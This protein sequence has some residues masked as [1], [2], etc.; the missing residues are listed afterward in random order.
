[1]G[2]RVW[3]SH[4]RSGTL[5][6][7]RSRPRTSVFVAARWFAAIV[8]L[9][10]GLLTVSMQSSAED[11]SNN[12]V[13]GQ[14]TIN[15]SVG[16]GR[17]LRFDGLLQSVFI[18]APEIADVHV[19]TADVVYVYGKKSGVTYLVAR[20]SEQR[21]CARVQI[22]IATNSVPESDVPPKLECK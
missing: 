13:T 16:E 15:L 6:N 8:P 3:V 9:L 5:C 19:V 2:I 20:S 11:F 18:A 7:N 14:A 10:F 1:M 22:R 4:W 12:V 17:I 21:V